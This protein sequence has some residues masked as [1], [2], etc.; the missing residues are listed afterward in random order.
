MLPLAAVATVRALK[1][2]PRMNASVVGESLV[3]RRQ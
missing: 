3:I 2:F 1:E